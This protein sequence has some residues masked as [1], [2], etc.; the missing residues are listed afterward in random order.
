MFQVRK[1]DVLSIVLDGEPAIILGR[2]LMTPRLRRLLPLRR[3]LCV[4]GTVTAR[5]PGPGSPE[6]QSP[7]QSS[8]R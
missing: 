7:N 4:E 2:A 3:T 6:D 1:C 8:D 5:D